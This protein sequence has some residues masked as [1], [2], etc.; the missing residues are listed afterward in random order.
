MKTNI[1]S[2]NK[3]VETIYNLPLNDRLELMNLLEHNIADARRD[4]IQIN[5]LESK[6]ELENGKLEFS[7]SIKKLKKIL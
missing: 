3:I 4:E 1:N 5:Y 6:K 2:F 7:S